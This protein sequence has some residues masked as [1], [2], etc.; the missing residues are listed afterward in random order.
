[1]KLYQ[2]TDEQQLL[3]DEWVAERPDN[4]AWVARDF[5]PWTLYEFKD[6]GQKVTLLSFGEKTDGSVDL[7]VY[8]SREHNTTCLFERSVFG[9]SPELLRVARGEGD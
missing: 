7:T 5:N 9:V 4:V 2:P 6:T 8:V 3:W 1:M